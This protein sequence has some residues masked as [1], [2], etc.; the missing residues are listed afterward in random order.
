MSWKVSNA[1]TDLAG[2]AIVAGASVT[3]SGA[4]DTDF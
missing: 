4:V 3:E 1:T 2:N